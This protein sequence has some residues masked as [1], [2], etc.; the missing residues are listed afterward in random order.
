M[1]IWNVPFSKKIN[2][3]IPT[4]FDLNS[5][6]PASVYNKN[7]SAADQINFRNSIRLVFAVYNAMKAKVPRV[8]VHILNQCKLLTDQPIFHDE[9]WAT[10]NAVLACSNPT[11][12]RV[13]YY[14]DGDY[15]FSP[16]GGYPINTGR[17]SFCCRNCPVV[18]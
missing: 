3:I 7:P 17:I 18:N 11:I 6:I 5:L 15:Q 12:S 4:A 14:D 13:V 2:F 16:T 10:R 8:K 1:S 9:F